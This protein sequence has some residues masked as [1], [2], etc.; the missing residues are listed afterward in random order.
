MIDKDI[1]IG[2]YNTLAI[3]KRSENGLYLKAEDQSEVLLPNIY[4]TDSMK[5]DDEIEVFIYK[6]SEDRV[7]A[8]TLKPKAILGEFAFLEVIDQNKDGFFLDW[9][10]AKDLF[11]PKREQKGLK[12]GESY[13]FYLDL[14][15]K[16]KR[17]FASQ[18]IGKY[19]NKKPH[20]KANQEVEILPFAKT[21]LGYKAII[22]DSYS[23]MIYHN[24]IFDKITLAQK[25]RAFVKRVRSDGLVDLKLQPPKEVAKDSDTLK[26]INILTKAGGCLPLNYKSDPEVIKKEF[27]MSKKAYK[28][29]LTS[30]IDAKKLI[31]DDDGMRVL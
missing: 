27:K 3:A 22:K 20:F 12:I 25:L 18:K 7:I 17:V 19:L 21:P 16:T 15:N 29:A 26:I 4:T 23:G 24:E 5:I 30:L 6:D 31:V 2:K 13:L 10:L 9:G 14:D 28:R 1:S 8:T 11:V